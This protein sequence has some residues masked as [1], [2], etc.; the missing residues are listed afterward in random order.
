MKR[1]RNKKAVIAIG[2]VVILAIIGLLVAAIL[3]GNEFRRPRH[4]ASDGNL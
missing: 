4:A 2:L 3:H 1:M